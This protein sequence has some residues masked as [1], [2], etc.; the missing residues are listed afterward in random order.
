MEAGPAA[1][2]R[3]QHCWGANALRLTYPFPHRPH[4][5]RSCKP[6]MIAT[7]NPEEGPLRE[8]LLDRIAMTLS[9]DVMWSSPQVGRQTGRRRSRA[10]RQAGARAEQAGRQAS[11]ELQQKRPVSAAPSLLTGTLTQERVNAV[12]IAGRFQDSPTEVL[13]D[14]EDTTDGLRSQ[15]REWATRACSGVP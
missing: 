6:L 4:L 2:T 12:E 5:P 9:A 8:H 3:A 11:S 7:Y 15:V 13:S 10:G 14:T 1:A